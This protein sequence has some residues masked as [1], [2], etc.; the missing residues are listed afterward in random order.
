M[1]RGK[2]KQPQFIGIREK[3][4]PNSR[5]Y[6]QNLNSEKR[7]RGKASVPWKHYLN[8]HA[9]KQRRLAMV[10]AMG[11]KVVS[12]ECVGQTDGETVE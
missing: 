7:K 3:Q 2:E 10:E 1:E 5:C 12:V 11:E 8:H 9:G 6:S 4:Q